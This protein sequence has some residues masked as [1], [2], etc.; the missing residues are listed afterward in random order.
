MGK[1]D[2]SIRV[3]S[4]VLLTPVII[5]FFFSGLVYLLLIRIV[6]GTKKQG[7][8]FQLFLTGQ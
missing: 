4:D 6:L 8:V 5:V 2:F 1:E 3:V 7:D